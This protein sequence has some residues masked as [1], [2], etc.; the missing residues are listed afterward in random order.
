MRT[1]AL[2]LREKMEGKLDAAAYQRFYA[3]AHPDAECEKLEAGPIM[4]PLE[5]LAAKKEES[6]V[7]SQLEERASVLLQ[8]TVAT[9]L[10][11]EDDVQDPESKTGTE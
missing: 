8:N 10:V 2:R 5:D 1:L 7:E 3:T 9:A 6:P 11:V 4:N